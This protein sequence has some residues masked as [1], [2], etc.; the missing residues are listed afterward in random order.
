[1]KPSAQ[2][3]LVESY[4]PRLGEEECRDAA[5][6]ARIVADELS[7]DGTAVR[8]LYSLFVAEDETCFHV[9]EGP[10]LEAVAAATSK[11]EL[12]YARIV[13]VTLEGDPYS[14]YAHPS[15]RETSGLLSTSVESAS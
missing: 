4:I 6:R 11:A 15:R 12:A 8:Y 9:F 2:R 10:S 13:P 5:R 1:V 14:P 7:G 3:Y